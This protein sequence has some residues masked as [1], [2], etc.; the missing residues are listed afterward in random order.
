MKGQVSQLSLNIWF[1]FLRC[2]D[3]KHK[4]ISCFPQ[5]YAL[6]I[7]NYICKAGVNVKGIERNRLD[8]KK[9]ILKTDLILK[10][11]YI[12]MSYYAMNRQSFFSMSCFSVYFLMPQF[13]IP[14]ES[15]QICSFN[16]LPTK[17]SSLCF[18]SVF[19]NC[20]C[21][22][23]QICIWRTFS[24][25]LKYIFCMHAESYSWDHLG[26]IQKFRIR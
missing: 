19:Q 18:I 23:L 5:G 15:I 17:L 25:H 26:N 10:N 20:L 12:K 22:H 16:S 4:N 2:S 1:V 24:L 7:E 13:S 21:L 9:N 14:T 8:F 3:F 6:T 11:I